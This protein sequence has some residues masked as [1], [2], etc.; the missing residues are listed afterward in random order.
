[1]GTDPPTGSVVE[2][3][4]KDRAERTGRKG[5]ALRRRQHPGGRMK[6]T[7]ITRS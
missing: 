6:Y 2:K 5:Q 7:T 1:L 4:G 3:G